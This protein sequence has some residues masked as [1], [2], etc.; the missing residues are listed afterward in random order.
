MNKRLP[1]RAGRANLAWLL[2]LT[3]IVAIAALTVFLFVDFHG[4]SHAAPGGA[5]QPTLLVYCAANVQKPVTSIAKDYEKETGA[6]IELQFGPSQVL[7]TSAQ[8]SKKGDLYIPSDDSYIGIGKQKDMIAEVIPLA[9][10]SPVLGVKKGNPKN[11]QSLQDILTGDV[12]LSQANPETAAIGKV[13]RSA[14]VN[15]GNWDAIKAKT[16]VFQATISDV[17]NDIKIGSVDAGFLYDSTVR[18]FEGLDMVKMPQLDNLVSAVPVAVLKSTIQPTEALRFARYLGASDKGLATF[19]KMGFEVADGD[20][21]AQTP[22]LN[23]FAGAMLRPAIEQT[24]QAFEER[25][26]VKI[27]RVYNGCGILV[28]QM[29]AG[30]HPDAYI[31]CD[32]TFMNQVADLYLDTSDISSNQLVILVPKGNPHNVKSLKDLGMPGL[33]VGVG[34]EKQCAL[35]ALTKRTMDTVGVTDEITRNIKVQVPTGDMLVNELRTDALDAVIVYISNAAAAGDKVEAMAIDVPCA[36]AIQPMGVG[37]ESQY[38]NLMGRLMDQIKSEDSKRRFQA[39]GFGWK[40][41]AP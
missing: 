16:I 33:R 39:M 38:K 3:S 36:T 24:I 28:S 2:F 26:G 34:H 18:Q 7:L 11:I 29:K 9:R 5:A 37:K 35:G 8:V 22:Q 41:A 17:A 25:E 31:A 40:V 27:T 15:S 30:Q 12:R 10:Q 14:L 13:V 6:K 19:K 23:M 32:T 1:M 21:W 20:V 4:K